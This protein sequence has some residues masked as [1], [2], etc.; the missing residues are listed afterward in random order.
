MHSPPPKQHHYAIEA[1]ELLNECR[2]NLRAIVDLGKEENTN[3]NIL[4]LDRTLL[5]TEQILHY[6]LLSLLEQERGLLSKQEAWE[7]GNGQLMSNSS[8]GQQN[9]NYGF[10][11]SETQRILHDTTTNEKK[12]ENDSTVN[13]GYSFQ[14]PSAFEESTHD[15]DTS[16]HAVTL[17]P[18][19]ETVEKLKSVMNQKHKRKRSI[20]F[21]HWHKKNEQ[22]IEQMNHQQKL[23]QHLKSSLETKN[24]T[25]ALK[26]AQKNVSNDCVEFPG[27]L[28]NKANIDLNSARNTNLNFQNDY[29]KSPPFALP[30]NS[31]LAPQSITNN[32][33]IRGE[34][35]AIDS[36]LFRLIVVLQ[37]CLVRIEEARNLLCS[38]RQIVMTKNETFQGDV[39]KRKNEIQP[40]EYFKWTKWGWGTVAAL[41]G[42]SA[43]FLTNCETAKTSAKS[44]DQERRITM[45]K[46]GTKALGICGTSLF[47]RRCWRM[48]C[49][50]ARLLNTIFAIE[51]LHHQWMLVHSVQ[52][53]TNGL[54]T[55]ND[56]S[57]KQCQRL[58]KLIPFQKSNVSL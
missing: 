56:T 18:I 13:F 21:L 51:D 12:F 14:S 57:E 50:N 29:Q 10:D 7:D 43:Y 33:N 20:S 2:E 58:L 47:L 15:L 34:K 22:E 4:D 38:K 25:T 11:V 17:E 8:G 27:S 9:P 45:I 31:K 19:M 35:T 3:A 23:Q 1:A 49:M 42:A 26:A 16:N 53:D 37:L 44:A 55:R 54:I 39:G 5:T 30:T 28:F 36:V 41:F 24:Y 46:S 52:M 40:N 32:S 6:H 48:L